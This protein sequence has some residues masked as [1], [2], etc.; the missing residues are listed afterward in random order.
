[1]KEVI[2]RIE[3]LYNVLPEN[4]KNDL[5]ADLYRLKGRMESEAYIIR[6][7]PERLSVWADADGWFFN[8]AENFLSVYSENILEKSS[9][10]ARV[11]GL[12]F[13]LG[14][15]IPDLCWSCSKSGRTVKLKSLSKKDRGQIEAFEERYKDETRRFLDE[16]AVILDACV[17]RN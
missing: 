11:M 7:I 17:E 15:E 12:R 4:K 1:M 2:D 5:I 8:G 14:E 10:T 6:F 13:K 9:R 3:V 16:L